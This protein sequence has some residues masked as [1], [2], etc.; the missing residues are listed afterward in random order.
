MHVGRDADAARFAS[1][2]AREKKHRKVVKPRWIAGIG[3]RDGQ[4][5][6]S[7]AGFVMIDETL[8]LCKLSAL[9]DLLLSCIAG[10]V[11][12]VRDAGRTPCTT[13]QVYQPC[14]ERCCMY[15]FLVASISP[16]VWRLGA[17]PTTTGT[18][19]CLL[20]QFPQ[21]LLVSLLPLLLLLSELMTVLLYFLP[22]RVCSFDTQGRDTN[23]SRV[24][25]PGLVLPLAC[26]LWRHLA[27]HNLLVTLVT[28]FHGRIDAM[29][30]MDGGHRSE[31]GRQVFLALHFPSTAFVFGRGAN[32]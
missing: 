21:S 19:S 18:H 14:S 23:G 3:S 20:L 32:V 6:S 24:L 26:L 13:P 4:P 22:L 16:S 5:E 2:D 25:N 17:A 31:A 10:V 7:A 30:G 15:T 28:G 9:E 1:A 12:V 27:L 29:S 8:E 11:M